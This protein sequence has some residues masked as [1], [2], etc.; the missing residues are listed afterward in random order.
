[1]DV[2]NALL[3]IRETLRQLSD[4]STGM[5]KR[6]GRRIGG[7][8]M[9]VPSIVRKLTLFSILPP[10]ELLAQ[11]DGGFIAESSDREELR[12]RWERASGSYAQCGPGTRSFLAPNDIR[13]LE[14]VHRAP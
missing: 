10:Q 1:M 3:K 2:S 4:T 12:G 14:S 5:E 8:T 9:V 11:L 7:S 6:S 13:P